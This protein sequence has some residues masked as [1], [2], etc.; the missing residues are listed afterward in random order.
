MLPK[1]TPSLTPF[2]PTYVFHFFIV[3]I[4]ITFFLIF[5]LHTHLPSLLPFHLSTSH[6]VTSSH[7]Y[8]FFHFMF[9]FSP[10]SSTTQASTC[11]RQ[12]LYLIFRSVSSLATC[13][14]LWSHR[15][16]FFFFFFFMC[17]DLSRF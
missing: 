3:F 10:C 7:L 17:I 8:H 14:A 1:P 2:F 12:Y 5:L 4:T 13:H 9:C 11:T 15:Q 16:H 6:C